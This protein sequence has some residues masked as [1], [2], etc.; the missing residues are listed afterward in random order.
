MP[1]RPWFD[2][3]EVGSSDSFVVIAAMGAL[4]PGHILIVSRRH[5]ERIADLEL[6]ELTDLQSLWAYW[7]S[8]LDRKWAEPKF[9]FEHGGRSS[10]SSASCIAHAHIQMLPLAFDPIASYDDFARMSSVCELQSYRSLDYIMI[11][12]RDGIFLREL[13]STQIGQFFRRQIS[14]MLGRPDSWDYLAFPNLEAMQTTITQLIKD[15]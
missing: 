4:T 5:V 6:D 13:P 1:D 14:A 15:E 12:G 2:F 3:A 9:V 8:K 10:T 7:H 11:W